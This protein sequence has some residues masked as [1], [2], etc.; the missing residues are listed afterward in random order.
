[1]DPNENLKEQL[2]LA[3]ALVFDGDSSPNGLMPSAQRL[4]ELVLALDEWIQKGGFLPLAWQKPVDAVG[5]S[6]PTKRK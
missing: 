5:T 2:R 6:L 1:M 4:G 3:K